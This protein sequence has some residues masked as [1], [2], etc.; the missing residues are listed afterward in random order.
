MKRILLFLGTNLAVVLVLGIVMNIVFSALGI[1]TQ[2]MGG[3]L[4]FCAIFGFGGSIIS[5]LISKWMAKRSTGAQ[6]IT[7]PRNQTEAWL[8]DTVARQA[9]AAGIG[10]PEVAIYNAPDMNAFATGAKRDDALVAVSTGLLDN[11]TRDEVEAV[12]AHEVSHIANGD[13][14]TLTLIQGVVNTFVMF[15]ARIIANV[16]SSA[17]S[18]NNEN[19]QG[20]GTFAY[21]ATVFVLEMVFGILASIIVMWFSRQR[22]YRADEGSAKLVGKDKMINALQRLGGSRE[23]E[24]EGSMMAFGINGKRAMSE[25]FLSHPPLEKRIAALRAR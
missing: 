13:M 20:M 9:K 14:V 19:G 7:T 23:P 18:N 6:V 24:M 12:L 16:I 3:L 10:M 4:I 21:I 15:L 5:L 22:E 11:M 25:L 2:S 8:V 1:S 17:M